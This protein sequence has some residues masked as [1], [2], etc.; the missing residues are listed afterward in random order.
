MLSLDL[1]E[2]TLRFSHRGS[3]IVTIASVKGPIHAAV[4]LTSSKQAVSG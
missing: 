3:I 1:K 4:T 2:G